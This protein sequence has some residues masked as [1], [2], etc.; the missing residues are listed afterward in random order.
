[1]YGGPLPKTIIF[2]EFGL[3]LAFAVTLPHDACRFVCKRDR[4][5]SRRSSH[6]QR[7]HPPCEFS[8]VA[9]VA[10]YSGR[11]EHK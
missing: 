1:M 6:Q 3:G 7:I 9:G 4:Y 8:F 11:A 10:D 2:D 5:D